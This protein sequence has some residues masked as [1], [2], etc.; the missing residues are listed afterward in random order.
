VKCVQVAKTTT[1]VEP[2]PNPNPLSECAVRSVMAVVV[3]AA[4]ERKR[5]E[6]AESVSL[7]KRV[8]VAAADAVAVVD[9]LLL[10]T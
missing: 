5:S 3:V 9:L 7:A 2:K 4:D 8:V 1:T 6:V 10:A